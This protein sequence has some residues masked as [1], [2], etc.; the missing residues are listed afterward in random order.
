MG[1][2]LFSCSGGTTR[3]KAALCAEEQARPSGFAAELLSLGLP[4]HPWLLSLRLSAVLASCAS[5][6]PDTGVWQCLPA[7]PF[8][9]QQGKL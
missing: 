7:F 8:P 4:L 9:D 3:W 5:G 1:V 2:S 6:S